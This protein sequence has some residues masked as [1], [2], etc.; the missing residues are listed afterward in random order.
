MQARMV[1]HQTDQAV[2]AYK[3][4]QKA[5]TA[6]EFAQVRDAAKQLGVPGA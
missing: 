3:D 5:L 1:L 2:Q 4:A 6:S